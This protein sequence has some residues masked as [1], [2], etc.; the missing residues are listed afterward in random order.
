MSE[1]L[2]EFDDVIEVLAGVGIVLELLLMLVMS[3]KSV[4]MSVTFSKSMQMSDMI[5]EVYPDL[6]DVQ[7]VLAENSDIGEILGD[8][9]VM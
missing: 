8:G 1:V 7:K 6:C 5:L 9:D 2:A 3:V 4:L